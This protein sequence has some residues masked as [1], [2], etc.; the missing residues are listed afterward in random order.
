MRAAFGE[1]LLR[2][3]DQYHN[4]VVLT[5]DVAKPTNVYAF[6]QRHPDRFF[7]VGISEQ[8]MVGI[9]A[10]FSLSG[11]I[12]VIAAFAPFLMRAWEQIRSTIARVS[13]NVKIVGTHAGLSASEEGSSH[14]SLEDVALMRVLPHMTVVVPGDKQEIREATEALIEMSGPTYLRL[15]R[16]EDLRFLEGDR[17]F[18][19]GKAAILRDGSDMTVISNGGMTPEVLKAVEQAK[20]SAR[21]LHMPTVKP[22]DQDAVLSAA[23]DT[24]HIVCVEEHSI[25]GGL[26]GAV[27]ELV[28]DKCPVL[29]KRLGVNDDFG[30]SG[31]RDEL[32]RKHGLEAAAIARE[33][34]AIKGGNVP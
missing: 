33:L 34:A 1:T 31:P 3:G 12:P 16:D 27:A 6:S 15:G 21:V 18:Q 30:E 8:D 25:I 2:L 23:R 5:A 13:L 7:N 10:G 20:V 28:A 22:L 14:Q 9:A 17:V 4:L 11:N 29:V 32:M 19:L 26:G 24:G